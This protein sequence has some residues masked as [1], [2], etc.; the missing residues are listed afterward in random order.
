MAGNP[1]APPVASHSS[2]CYCES[3]GFLNPETNADVGFDLA[4]RYQVSSTGQL[5]CSATLRHY[6]KIGSL[7][8]LATHQRPLALEPTFLLILKKDGDKI[9]GFANL[10]KDQSKYFVTTHFEMEG[11]QTIHRLSALTCHKIDGTGNPLFSIVQPSD[12]D[13]YIDNLFFMSRSYRRALSKQN[14]WLA[15]GTSLAL[16][17]I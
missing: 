1:Q 8:E 16:A 15:Q 10:C 17:F 5:A 2:R 14:C 11:L 9:Q 6:T 4:T 12:I 13:L 7:K 3:V